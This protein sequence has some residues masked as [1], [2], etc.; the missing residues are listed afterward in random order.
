MRNHWGTPTRHD[1]YVTLAAISSPGVPRGRFVWGHQSG[2][3][4][5]K[6]PPLFKRGASSCASQQQR[7]R[8]PWGAYPRPSAPTYLPLSC[9]HQTRQTQ[10][11]C[12]LI[13]DF[14]LK[15]PMELGSEFNLQWFAKNVFG[16]L[17]Q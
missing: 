14:Q 16:Q 2:P 4:G 10:L 12:F 8:G 5:R 1:K 3:A 11:S 7:Q 9:Q 13:S 15:A 6:S 17:V